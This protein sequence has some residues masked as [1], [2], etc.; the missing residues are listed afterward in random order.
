MAAATPTPRRW[1]LPCW[2][3][4]HR[5]HRTGYTQ[6]ALPTLPSYSL[7]KPALQPQPH[8][9]HLWSCRPVRAAH[10][11]EPR[12]STPFLHRVI[13]G[14]PAPTASRCFRPV[15]PPLLTPH[16]QDHQVFDQHKFGL[17]TALRPRFPSRVPASNRLAP[18]RTATRLMNASTKV[19][20][21]PAP[22]RLL[23][24]FAPQ[25][26]LCCAEPFPSTVAGQP[27]ARKEEGD[28]D[29]DERHPSAHGACRLLH[30][31][32]RRGLRRSTCLVQAVAAR[33][34]LADALLNLLRPG[35]RGIRH[36]WGRLLGLHQ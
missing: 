18:Q 24:R 3:K 8:A 35:R 19:C 36:V 11:G 28:A 5:A 13:S 15:H 32:Q 16:S 10:L 33:A 31:G 25:V 22:Q 21:R 30:G 2:W 12:C 7:S 9:S 4:G 1:T 14:A 26:T 29:Q 23:H 34:A 17:S 20:A 27:L 6:R